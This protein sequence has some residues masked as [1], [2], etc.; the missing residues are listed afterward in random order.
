MAKFCEWV[1]QKGR[2]R[3]VAAGRKQAVDLMDGGSAGKINEAVAVVTATIDEALYQ[4]DSVLVRGRFGL[5]RSGEG[6][7]IRDDGRVAQPE[8]ATHS[9]AVSEGRHGTRQSR[10]AY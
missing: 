10:E 7:A 2:H 9:P 6:R 1:A 4:R 8:R 5:D 3:I